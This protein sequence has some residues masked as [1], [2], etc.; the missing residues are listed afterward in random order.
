MEEMATQPATRITEED[1]LR[2]ERAATYK[3]EFVNGEIFAMSGGTR[4][5]S[6]SAANWIAHL[7][8]KLRGENCDVFTSDMRVRTTASGSYVYPDVSV[9][10]GATVTNEDD[11]DI[12]L[13]PKI[14]IEVLSPSTADYDR[15][16]KFELYREI[17][18]L[19]EY[20]LTHSDA[21]HVE[22]F[23]RQADSSWI[24]REYKG[25]ENSLRLA[26]I[27]CEIGLADI[28]ERI[29]FN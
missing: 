2:L 4:R 17:P 21:P 12:L 20:V 23:A 6:R 15:G 22:H 19:Q 24:F 8:Y 16:K 13:N 18:S 29:L 25:L 14:I 9:A 3:S 11:D 10:C 1:Y 7:T 27:N 26:S 5:H 28:Y